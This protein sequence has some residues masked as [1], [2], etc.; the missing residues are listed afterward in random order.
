MDIITK[1]WIDYGGTKKNTGRCQDLGIWRSGL[2]TIRKEEFDI[3]DG[4]AKHTPNSAAVLL[5]LV[6]TTRAICP[7][8]VIELATSRLT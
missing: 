5:L 2:L 6:F 7:S 1:E 4:L 8:R 3:T